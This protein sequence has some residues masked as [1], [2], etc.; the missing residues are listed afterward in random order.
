MRAVACRWMQRD[1]KGCISQNHR[2]TPA[3]AR[4]IGAHGCGWIRVR[5]TLGVLR[6]ETSIKTDDLFSSVVRGPGLDRQDAVT[7]LETRMHAPTAPANTPIASPSPRRDWPRR[8]P[9]GPREH[10]PG[11]PRPFQIQLPSLSPQSRFPATKPMHLGDMLR[12]RRQ[13][14]HA[15]F[16]LPVAAPHQRTRPTHQ[17]ARG[18]FPP[19]KFGRRDQGVQINTIQVH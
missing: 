7:Y 12:S 15:L 1:A 4:R 19:D 3:E 5:N 13:N 10:L 2:W 14:L 16:Q 17:Q 9:A 18:I 8:C 6:R 11:F